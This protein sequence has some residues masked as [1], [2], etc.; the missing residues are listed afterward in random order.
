MLKHQDLALANAGRITLPI[1][2]MQ[3]MEDV[4]V[5]PEASKKFYDALGT[6]AKKRRWIGYEGLY[7]EILNEP[8]KEE[9]YKEILKWVNKHT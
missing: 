2:V 4:I 9:I 3:G 6:P 8:V 1:L 7:H 5:S